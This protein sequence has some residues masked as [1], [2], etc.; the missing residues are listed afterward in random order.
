MMGLCHQESQTQWSSGKRDVI[1]S[2]SLQPEVLQGWLVLPGEPLPTQQFPETLPA[3]TLPS[4]PAPRSNT[5]QNTFVI[6]YF[7][8]KYKK[9]NW[10]NSE[11]VLRAHPCPPTPQQVPPSPFLWYRGS[12]QLCRTAQGRGMGYRERI[13][14]P[15][16]AFVVSL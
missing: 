15:G 8:Y 7:F 3:G 13:C 2:S 11:A 9:L 5:S 16:N 6:Y 10:K 4:C 1:N 14:H 12:Q